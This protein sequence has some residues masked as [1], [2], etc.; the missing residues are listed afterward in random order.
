MRSL[1]MSSHSRFMMTFSS[2][3]LASGF[4]ALTSSQILA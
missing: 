3:N 2:R 1:M 4:L